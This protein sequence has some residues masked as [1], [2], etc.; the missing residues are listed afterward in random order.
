[1]TAFEIELIIQQIDGILE[2]DPNR[3]DIQFLFELKAELV[4]KLHEIK[5]E[6]KDE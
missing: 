5:M 6:D 1:V 3:S 4:C 2:N